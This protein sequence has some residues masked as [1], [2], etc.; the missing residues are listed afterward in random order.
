MSLNVSVATLHVKSPSILRYGC[1]NWR[2]DIDS[3]FSQDCRRALEKQAVVS[4]CLPIRLFLHPRGTWLPPN[5]FE[6]KMIMESCTEMFLHLPISVI[7]RHEWHALYIET[8]AHL[9]PLWLL[10]LP[11]LPVSLRFLCSPLLP[12]L[13]QLPGL[14]IF[15]CCN[16]SANAVQTYRIIFSLGGVLAS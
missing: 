3:H 1:T 7:L 9:W 2:I 13:H 15:L 11:R 6:R 8:C 5:G 14:P 12:W 16:W 4:S 10:T